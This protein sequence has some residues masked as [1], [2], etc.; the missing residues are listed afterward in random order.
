MFKSQVLLLAALLLVTDVFAARISYSA[1]YTNGDNTQRT[2][3][4]GNVPDDKA[5]LIVNNMQTWSNDKYT[6]TQ[7]RHNII[8]VANVE[9]AASKGLASEQVQ[10]M[11]SI[12]NNNIKDGE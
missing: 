6:A 3:K 8:V 4:L 9:A 12:V 1:K 10:D 5:D 7:T 11:Q 2:Q